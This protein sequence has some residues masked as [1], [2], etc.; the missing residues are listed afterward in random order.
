M[1]DHLTEEEAKSGNELLTLM[2]NVL[3]IWQG[4][5]HATANVYMVFFRPVRADSAAVTFYALGF[6]A[7]LAMVNALVT[8]FGSDDAQKEWGDLYVSIRRRSKLRNAVAHGLVVLH[9]RRHRREFLIGRS[10][11]DISKSSDPQNKNH[12]LDVKKLK[13]YCRYFQKLAH[14]LDAF[15]KSLAKD[16][17][18]L[19]RL[20]APQQQ[21]LLNEA[22]YPLRAQIPPKS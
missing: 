6:Q 1:S 3:A 22:A 8:H 16:R 17:A 15:S 10:V 5:E 14:Q 7:Q 2:G 18:L 13:E 11:Y 4:V 12:V 21:F 9:G 19:S 20:N